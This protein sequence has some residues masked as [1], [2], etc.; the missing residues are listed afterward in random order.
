MASTLPVGFLESRSVT[1][2]PAKATS[3]Q[4]D[5]APLRLL[6]R[7]CRCSRHHHRTVSARCMLPSCVQPRSRLKTAEKL[8]LTTVPGKELVPRYRRAFLHSR[9]WFAC[10]G[11]RWLRL[12]R[13]LGGAVHRLC[14]R[15]SDCRD[16]IVSNILTGGRYI[17][18]SSVLEKLAQTGFSG[19]SA[20]QLGEVACWCDDWCRA[21]GDGRYCI[22]A[23]TFHDLYE[24]WSE[25]DKYNGIPVDLSRSIDEVILSRLSAIL[26]EGDIAGAAGLA[27]AFEGEV[28]ALL[29][30]PGAWRMQRG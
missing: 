27:A 10:P 16:I 14:P 17:M 4:L 19:V 20:D 23:A 12:E 26:T 25:H 22:L 8:S 24:W 18:D 13:R 2:G 6:R 15:K 1:T 21:T 28:M 7:T 9:Y 11:L 5:T 30:P 29:L 3:T